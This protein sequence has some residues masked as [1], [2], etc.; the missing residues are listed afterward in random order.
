MGKDAHDL[1]A[2]QKRALEAVREGGRCAAIQRHYFEMIRAG[3][4]LLNKS[5]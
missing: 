2:S 3:W 4:I 1:T 5:V